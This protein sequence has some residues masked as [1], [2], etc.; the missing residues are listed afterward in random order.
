M[1]GAASFLMLWLTVVPEAVAEG[2]GWSQLG[3]V[4]SEL[5][6]AG[7]MEYEVVAEAAPEGAP[8]EEVWRLT[9]ALP[10]CLRWRP[11][12]SRTGTTLLR[13]D[14]AFRWEAEG[15]VDHGRPPPPGEDLAFDLLLRPRA[16]LEGVYTARSR[17]GRPG[18]VAVELAARE[19]GVGFAEVTL[20]F[21]RS[22]ARLLAMRYRGEEGPSTEW[23]FA[24]PRPVAGD[25]CAPP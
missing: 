11:A 9:V 2:A 23:L 20:V 25:P 3:E 16:E 4:R 18:Q 7:A 24:A 22:G 19:P 8:A 1:K 14:G 17:I 15:A 6:I 13:V 10:G 21:E 12:P 5:A